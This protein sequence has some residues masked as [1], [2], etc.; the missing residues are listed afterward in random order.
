MEA[1]NSAT[2]EIGL[3]IADQLNSRIDIF[4]NALGV[5]GTFFFILIGYLTW[6]QIRMS[7]EADRRLKEIIEGSKYIQDRVE[8]I[9]KATK[10]AKK[11]S[12]LLKQ[13]KTRK[14]VITAK[15]KREIDRKLR[16]L[17][18]SIGELKKTTGLWY[19]TT[20]PTTTT[21]FPSSLSSL[22]SGSPG[23]LI[24]TES[25]EKS[26]EDLRGTILDITTRNSNNQKTS[27]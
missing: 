22:A 3:M 1:T 20:V 24:D 23:Q 27:K 13:P 26:V 6:N 14:T 5:L 7:K 4:I 19:P 18:K 10:D 15:K 8:I 25:L 2:L 9:T 16:E 12:T 17:E 21:M 11:L